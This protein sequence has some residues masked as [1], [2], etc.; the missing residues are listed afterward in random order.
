MDRRI[1]A[2]REVQTSRQVPPHLSAMSS[3]Q[4]SRLSS[5]CKLAFL[6]SGS[7]VSLLELAYGHSGSGTCKCEWIARDPTKR[8]ITK[9][10]SERDAIRG[11]VVKVVGLTVVR[12]LPAQGQN[13]R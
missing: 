4:P 11:N 7:S 13:L 8:R 1:R 3:R 5:T 10:L 6:F 12:E 2:G 9:E